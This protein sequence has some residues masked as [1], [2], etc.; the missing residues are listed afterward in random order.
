MGSGRPAGCPEMNRL[1]GRSGAPL[2]SRWRSRSCAGTSRPG[3]A[4]NP[5]RGSAAI[6]RSCISCGWQRDG[7]G[8]RSDSSS[9]SCHHVSCMHAKGAKGVLRALGTVCDLDVQLAELRQYCSALP[10]AERAAAAPLRSRLEEE[11]ARTPENDRHAGLGGDAALA[12]NARPC[13]RRFRRPRRARSAPGCDRDTQRVRGRFRKLKNAVRRLDSRSAMEEYHEVR[14]RAKQLRYATEC[15]LSL[16]GKP[17]EELLK[18]PAAAAG[19][20]WASSRMHT[21]HENRLTALAA[22]ADGSL[23]RDPVFHGGGSRSTT[24]ARPRRRASTLVRAWR[25]GAASAGEDC[26]GDSQELRDAG[27]ATVEAAT[28]DS[29]PAQPSP[30]SARPR[31]R[32]GIRCS[33]YCRPEHCKH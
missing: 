17:A 16:F 9:I 11:R 10:S 18:L 23:P 6:R 27:H 5:E 3:Y 2:R 1:A 31:H 13:Q 32:R 26:A 4:M 30:R 8:Q 29:C 14:R 19:A 15:G 28:Y 7:S 24:R 25:R 12:R 33:R 20:A 21:W 22:E